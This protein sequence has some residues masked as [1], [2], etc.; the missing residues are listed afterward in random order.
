[1][2]TPVSNAELSPALDP[3]FDPTFD[4]AEEVASGVPRGG[5]RHRIRDRARAI[6]R[7]EPSRLA[8]F[9]AALISVA[10]SFIQPR[11][12]A[13]PL[14]HDNVFNGVLYLM[15]SGTSPLGQR[16]MALLN[17]VGTIQSTA[18]VIL[19][20]AAVLPH[21]AF[22]APLFAV[23]RR[24][25]RYAVAL[26]L[27]T[28]LLPNLARPISNFIYALTAHVHWDLTPLIA[29]LEAP[30]I[31]WMQFHLASPLLSG[32]ASDFYSILWMLPTG[33]AA[34][35]LVVLDRPRALN[36]SILAFA[37]TSTLA[38][39]FFV[40]LP[41]FDPWSTNALYGAVGA[42]TH[43]RYLYAHPNVATLTTVNRQLHWAAGAAL[44]SL[45]VALP[46]VLALVFRADGL[47]KLSRFMFAVSAVTAFVVVYLGRHWMI[48]I[49][50]AVVFAYAM[51]KLAARVPFDVM[52]GPGGEW[53]SFRRA[54]P[55][56]ATQDAEASSA[57]NWLSG[58]F[59]VSGFAAL[60]YQIVWQRT[61]FG[62]I[63][64]NIE[65]VTLV[66]TV[67]MLGLG[68]GSLIGGAVSER[69]GAPLPTL[70][71]AAEI[72]VGVFGIFSLKIFQVVCDATLHMSATATAVITFAMLLPP[73]ILMGAT[74][75]ILVT[76]HVRTEGN[77]GQAV[78]RLYFMNTLGSAAAATL[79]G[80]LLL[81]FLGQSGTVAAAAAL[82]IAAGS[83]VVVRERR[84]D[85]RTLGEVR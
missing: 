15:W 14:P 18:F 68:I 79:A 7:A 71:A 23:A 73:T 53:A 2:L 84:D 45:H 1:M 55:R 81:G 76:N 59:V 51:A 80:L 72:G 62:I 44:P 25:Y 21:D 43:I 69:S 67:F 82:N 3:S 4:V 60:L 8:L 10:P 17:T 74:L 52:L 9:I 77:V 19:V 49:A 39:P 11:L 34:F 13:I 47:R 83:L 5:S 78:G 31:E 46:L 24:F 28:L 36:V 38:V 32:V 66:V 26:A 30:L 40:L 20:A 29:G 70:F 63:G 35:A 33:F 22:F 56:T 57:A 65:S 48:D 64:L 54:R 6:A 42:T 16:L 61:L 41:V 27:Y 75:P 58:I 50:G 85:R 37:L 12:D